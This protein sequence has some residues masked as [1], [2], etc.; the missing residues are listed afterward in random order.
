MTEIYTNPI[1]K[2]LSFDPNLLEFCGSDKNIRSLWEQIIVLCDTSG[3]T[4]NEYDNNNMN[5]R[6]GAYQYSD[7]L[8]VI[9]KSGHLDELEN[10]TVLK[11]KPV[12]YTQEEGIAHILVHLANNFNMTN[13]KFIL[14]SFDNDCYIVKNVIITISYELYLYAWSL[15]SL[16][17]KKFTSTNLTNALNTTINDFDKN[18][19]LIL[20]SDGRP[21]N[22]KQVFDKM[23]NIID[24][25]S[26]KNKIIDI[27]A[28]KSKNVS[29]ITDNNEYFCTTVYDRQIISSD[30]LVI[31]MLLNNYNDESDKLFLQFIAE[32]SLGCSGFSI[33]YDNYEYLINSFKKFL[34][35][36]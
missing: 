33:A 3:S 29:T 22:V 18:T 7:Q 9:R 8:M 6:R 27:F 2:H 30:E 12:I 23:N 35:K 5:H 32:K 17:T 10:E 25:F 26:E 15:D 11:N 21:N 24:G 31:K 20:A 34:E 13:V 36:K 14:A 16:I 1:N 19:L 4:I 28:F